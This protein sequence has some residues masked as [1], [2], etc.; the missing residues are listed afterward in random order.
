MNMT[1]K[2]RREVKRK[3]EMILVLREEVERSMISLREE[4]YRF[5]RKRLLLRLSKRS[6][7]KSFQGLESR[8]FMQKNGSYEE[9]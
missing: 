1:M 8:S 4:W 5:L 6:I 7:K 2:M 9:L 3:M